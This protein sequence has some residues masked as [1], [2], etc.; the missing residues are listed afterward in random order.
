MKITRLLTH[1]ERMAINEDAVLRGFYRDD[2]RILT[3]GTMWPEPWYYDP[4]GEREGQNKHVMF[5][6]VRKGE[7]GFLSIY[8]W[9]DWA[10]KTA[11]RCV[12]LPNGEMWEMDR[13][14]SNGEGW[15]V[16]G[17]GLLLTAHPSIKA[18]MV[19]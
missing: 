1:E 2:H 15:E 4:S 5:P 9:R 17:E 16:T 14:S 3:P 7:L 11:P 6:E 8:Y 13:K 19:G 12:V 10:D 18:I